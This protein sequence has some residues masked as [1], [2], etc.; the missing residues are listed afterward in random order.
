MTGKFVQVND[1]PEEPKYTLTELEDIRDF[2]DQTRESAEL[3]RGIGTSIGEVIDD[4][5]Q[6][7]SDAPGNENEKPRDSQIDQDA[8]TG[9]TSSGEDAEDGSRGRDSPD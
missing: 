1:P 3:H 5:D 4:T 2:F 7:D 8:N 6:I 9:D